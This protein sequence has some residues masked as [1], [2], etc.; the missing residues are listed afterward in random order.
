M[1]IQNISTTNFQGG[2]KITDAPRAARSSLT[3]ISKGKFVVGSFEGGKENF[4]IVARD[5]LHPLIADW[6]KQFG[7]N[8][9]YYPEIKL[10][11]VTPGIEHKALREMLD[12]Y[13]PEE[14]VFDETMDKIVKMKNRNAFVASNSDKYIANILKTLKL[15]MDASTVET[16]FGEK[17]FQN[18]AHSKQISIT[19]PNEE[20]VHYVKVTP[21]VSS[22]NQGYVEK[23]AMTSEGKILRNYTTDIDNWP[24]FKKNYNEALIK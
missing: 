14:I 4:F 11:M 12:T 24:L 7:L 21:L 5:N 8:C 9:L 3:K 17:K 19:A 2:Y 18:I 13:T 1:N 10:N 23:Y 20:L 22:S 6:V 15:D 16:K